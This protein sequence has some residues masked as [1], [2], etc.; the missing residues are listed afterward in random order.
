MRRPRERLSKGRGASCEQAYVFTVVIALKGDACDPESVITH[1]IP[2]S[3]VQL[4]P[5]FGETLHSLTASTTLG[6][7]LDLVSPATP[8]ET[9]SRNARQVSSVDPHVR[10]SPNLHFVDGDR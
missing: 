10:L 3:L 4:H 6:I 8:S 1:S 7:H 5:Q 2:R 9:H